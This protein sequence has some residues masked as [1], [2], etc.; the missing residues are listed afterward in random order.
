MNVI[1]SLYKCQFLWTLFMVEHKVLYDS[2]PQI[3][4][5]GKVL[6]FLSSFNNDTLRNHVSYCI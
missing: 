4:L 2:C 1:A 3:S 5:S 6:L